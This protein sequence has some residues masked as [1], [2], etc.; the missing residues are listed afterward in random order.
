MV[1]PL[2]EILLGV[3]M[4]YIVD[5]SARLVS[6]IVSSRRD[7]N[8]LDTEKFRCSVEVT[9]LVVTFALLWLRLKSS[10]VLFVR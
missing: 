5:R 7:M 3:L 4:V 10:G 8:D 9:L 6:S 2:E 1:K